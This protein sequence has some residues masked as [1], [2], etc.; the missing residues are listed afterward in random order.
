MFTSLIEILNAEYWTVTMQGTY[1]VKYLHTGTSQS[2][3][4]L[5]INNNLLLN[6]KNTFRYLL[7]YYIL[8]DF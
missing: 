2:Q 4:T 8:N 6:I 7:Y 1:L 3:Y 5:F